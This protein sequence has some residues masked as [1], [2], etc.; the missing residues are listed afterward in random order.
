M[1]DGFLQSWRFR[2]K[3]G[4]KRRKEGDNNRVGENKSSQFNA[5]V[6]SLPSFKKL[7]AQ[8]ILTGRY[9]NAKPE[10]RKVGQARSK[11]VGEGKEG[12]GGVSEK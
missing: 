1:Y 11:Q 12:I 9:P 10:E 5:T 4:T 2:Y 6:G 7:F 3:L 8:T